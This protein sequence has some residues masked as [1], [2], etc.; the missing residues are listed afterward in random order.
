MS[1]TPLS[2]QFVEGGDQA[3]GRGDESAHLDRHALFEFPNL[4]AT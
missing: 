2:N 3:D 1:S 4:C